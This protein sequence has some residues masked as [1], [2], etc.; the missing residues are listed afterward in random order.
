MIWLLLHCSLKE[1]DS[2]GEVTFRQ[3][4]PPLFKCIRVISHGIIFLKLVTLA[5]KTD[6]G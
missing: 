6:K 2:I 3:T 1:Q 5:Q 4:L